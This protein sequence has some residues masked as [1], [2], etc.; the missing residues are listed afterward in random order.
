MRISAYNVQSMSTVC[1]NLVNT[2]YRYEVVIMINKA[3]EGLVPISESHQDI[4]GYISCQIELNL[5]IHMEV[6]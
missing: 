4:D 6:K 3:V 2:Q 5:S 1:T